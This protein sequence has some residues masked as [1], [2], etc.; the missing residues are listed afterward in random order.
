MLRTSAPLKGALGAGEKLS[1]GQQNQ[2]I[3]RYRGMTDDELAEIYI[4]RATL[5]EEA[6][7]A[8]Q[9]VALERGTEFQITVDELTNERISLAQAKNNR[10]SGRWKYV[11]HCVALVLGA[12]IVSRLDT[13]SALLAGSLAVFLGWAGW[14]GSAQLVAA[15]RKSTIPNGIKVAIL[16]ALPFGYLAIYAL[17]FSVLPGP[18]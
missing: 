13:G 3:H 2:F 10:S 12:G 18:E 6:G 7:A 9:S 1:V 15:I 4:G 11:I 5:T 16:W 8:L 17:V 14:K